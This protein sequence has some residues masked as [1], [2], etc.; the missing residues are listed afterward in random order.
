M[1]PKPVIC[2]YKLEEV[3]KIGINFLCVFL[4]YKIENVIFVNEQVTLKNVK[5][6]PLILK[7]DQYYR[8]S[9]LNTLVSSDEIYLELGIIGLLLDMQLSTR[10]Q[11]FVNEILQ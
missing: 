9:V 2:F 1:V 4:N 3:Y 11:D 10:L 6:F 8:K 7:W 5:L